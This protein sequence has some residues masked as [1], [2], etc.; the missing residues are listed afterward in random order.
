[1]TIFIDNKVTIDIRFYVYN[2]VLMFDEAYSKG[3]HNVSFSLFSDGASL[4]LI[5]VH[6]LLHSSTR[7]SSVISEAALVSCK[8]GYLF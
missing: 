3:Y 2:E 5:T 8:D 4:S 6:R 1:M 7:H